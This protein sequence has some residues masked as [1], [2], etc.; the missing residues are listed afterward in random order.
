MKNE[1]NREY[2]WLK[3]IKDYNHFNEELIAKLYDEFCNIA[4]YKSKLRF[5]E[6]NKLSPVKLQYTFSIEFEGKK[7]KPV[8]SLHPENNDEKKLYF[9]WLIDRCYQ[10]YQKN[11]TDYNFETISINDLKLRFHNRKDS[12][13]NIIDDEIAL[14]KGRIKRKNVGSDVFSYITYKKSEPNILSD[15]KIS[16]EDLV[17]NLQYL[18]IEIAFVYDFIQYLLFLDEYKTQ[19]Y[20]K[21][22]DKKYIPFIDKSF[23]VKEDVDL[24]KLHCFLIDNKMIE[25]IDYQNFEK[26]FSEVIIKEEISKNDRINWILVNG[27]GETNWQTLFVLIY[28]ACIEVFASN[29]DTDI[30]RKLGKCFTAPNN[31]FQNVKNFSRA[32]RTFLDN[33]F[34][35][36]RKNK[37]AQS[38]HI[39]LTK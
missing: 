19:G 9:N 17:I 39:F 29:S 36:L 24:K 23:K 25:E 35:T 5:W 14:T 4:D 2:I 31:S 27:K 21:S 15:L 28:F 18:A 22:V 16:G 6:Q 7:Y 10:E 20:R 1:F 12:R 8:L 11:I 3:L 34:S 37:P 13:N 30:E 26:I 38:L 32:K 33:N